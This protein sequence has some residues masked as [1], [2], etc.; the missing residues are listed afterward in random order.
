MYFVHVVRLDC[1]S[2][3]VRVEGKSTASISYEQYLTYYNAQR[4]TTRK[5]RRKRGSQLLL[6]AHMNTRRWEYIVPV[7]YSE[8]R[9]RSA[10]GPSAFKRKDALTVG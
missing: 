9:H 2:S 6:V 3:Y 7:V 5:I 8:H 4:A 10:I 1:G